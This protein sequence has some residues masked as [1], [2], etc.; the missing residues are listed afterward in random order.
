VGKDGQESTWARAKRLCRLNVRQVEMAKKLGM[1]PKKLPSLNPSP[2]QR[3]KL[4]VGALIE[5]CYAKRFP[6]AGSLEETVS[7]IDAVLR[8]VQ[9][10]GDMADCYTKT[11]EDLVVF[12]ANALHNLEVELQR[13]RVEPDTLA[14]IRDD[15][16]HYANEIVLDGESRSL[17]DDEV[18]F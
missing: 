13:G 16:R 2:G 9:P 17:E 18:P 14:R 11:A 8:F 12:F 4:P 7:N 15:L 5:Q 6:R 10:A 1:N 3:W